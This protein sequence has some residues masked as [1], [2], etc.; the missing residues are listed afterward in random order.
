MTNPLAI[1]TRS[2]TKHYGRTG[3]IKALSSI[4]L[5]IKEGELFGFL[6]PNGAGKSTTIRT[7]LG[8]LHPTSGSASVLG[9]DIV[10]DSV[11]IRRRVGYLPSGFAVYD[12]MSGRE[13]LDHMRALSGR[14]SLLR[15]RVMEALELSDAI[16]K[17][18]V[19]DY[20]RGMRQKIGVVQALETD[21]ELLILDEPSEGLDP[22]MQRSLQ[23]L[24]LERVAAGRTVFFSSHLISEVERICN[25]VAIVR[26]GKLVALETVE[27][28]VRY[29]RRRVDALVARKPTR[30]TSLAGVF[31]V[32]VSPEGKSGYRINCEA[33]SAAV[34]KL[35]ARLQTSGLRDLLIEA[36]SLEEAF[37][38]YY[39]DARHSSGAVQVFPEIA[40]VK[41]TKPKAVAKRPAAKRAPAKRVPAKKSATKKRSSR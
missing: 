2:L 37:M 33:E 7:L 8:F 41:K 18:P 9:L 25:R 1:Q 39:G 6:G 40:E 26:G 13:Y 36:A 34:P 29:Q 3:E 12:Y 16:L 27:S 5:E 31:G 4:D 17:R 10:K 24:L 35:I 32:K 23:E 38:S 15:H 21:P 11:E 28:L 30:L 22:L 20:S 19:R 14:P